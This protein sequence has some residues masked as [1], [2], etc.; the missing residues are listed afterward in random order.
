[1][2]SGKLNIQLVNED[3]ESSPQPIDMSVPGW[4]GDDVGQNIDKVVTQKEQNTIQR[5]TTTVRDTPSFNG[6]SSPSLSGDT[7]A[8]FVQGDVVETN[9]QDNVGGVEDVKRLFPGEDVGGTPVVEEELVNWRVILLVGVG[10]LVLCGGAAVLIYRQN[11]S[12]N[13]E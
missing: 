3:G 10:V 4:L 8:T 12:E 5:T 6:Q 1:M 11:N 9:P 13:N 7:Q 2:L